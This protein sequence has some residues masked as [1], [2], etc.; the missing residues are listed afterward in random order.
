MSAVNAICHG[1]PF[2]GALVRVDQDV[3]IVAVA[4]PGGA[5]GVEAG[6]RITRDRVWHPSSA[7]PFVVLTWAEER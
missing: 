6:Y 1:G 2:H 3:G 7:V 4:D 5:D